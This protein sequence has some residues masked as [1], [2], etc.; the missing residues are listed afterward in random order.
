MIR[1]RGKFGMN[2]NFW[3]N[4][5]VIITGHTGFKGSWLSIWLNHLGAEI[6][7]VSIDPPSIPSLYSLSNIGDDIE[8][9]HVDIRN[10]N[11]INEVF[12]R[13]KPEIVFHLAAQSLV[14]YSYLH[15]V[16]TYETNVMGTLNILQAIRNASS[17]RSAIMVTSDK[18]YE[19]KELE[20]GYKES[21]P[22]GGKDLYSS[23]K[24]SAEHLISSYQNTY[25]PKDDY[26]EHQFAMA[27]V[28]AGNVIGGGD[29]AEDRLIPDILK[30]FQ[31]HQPVSIRYPNAVR[32]WQH[33]LEPLSGY[34]D[35]AEKLYSEGIKYS[36]AWNFGPSDM[37]AKPVLTVV[38]KMVKLWGEDA[39]WILD[40]EAHPSEANYLKLDCSKANSKLLWKPKWD[41]NTALRKTI[42]WSKITNKNG[43]YRECCLQQIY[44]YT[45]TK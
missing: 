31:L 24:A 8:S 36:E 30:A 5:K 20:L 7:G 26:Q 6:V 29:W 44:D 3:L 10:R 15:P 43:N 17:V 38:K 12:K 40:V 16:E 19:N 28:R 18:C 45:I 22:L 23:S 4:K 37:D 39:S 21:D 9:L 34:I 1:P 41:L 14:R 2:K 13:V 25:F 11:E 42:E 35:L 33:V 32:P 27:S